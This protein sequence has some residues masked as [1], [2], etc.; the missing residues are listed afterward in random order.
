[1]HGEV[2][3]Y[4]NQNADLTPHTSAKI[5][6]FASS[7]LD[8]GCARTHSGQSKNMPEIPQEHTHAHRRKHERRTHL[9]TCRNTLSR[10]GHASRLFNAHKRRPRAHGNI[11]EQ[12]HRRSEAQNFLQ[13]SRMI[14]TNRFRDFVF[15]TKIMVSASLHRIHKQMQA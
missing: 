14:Q 4:K 8:L 10:D 7:H 2:H 6:V 12:R 5:H 13:L 3:I 1:M 9:H 11:H 15:Q